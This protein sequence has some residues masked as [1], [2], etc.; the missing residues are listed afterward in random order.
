MDEEILTSICLLFSNEQ[1][2]NFNDEDAWV[3]EEEDTI[4]ERNAFD[5]FV[6]EGNDLQLCQLTFL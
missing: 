4:G 6:D 3:M 1:D 5:V 2:D